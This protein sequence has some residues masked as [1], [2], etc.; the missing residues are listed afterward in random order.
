MGY[1][2]Q[3][4][5]SQVFDSQVFNS[6]V[7]DKYKT[8]EVYHVV[9]P[10]YTGNFMPSKLDL[11]L[12]DVDEYV[13]S[14]TVTRVPAVATNEAKTN[15][16]L[17]EVIVNGDSPPPKRTVDGVKQTYPPTTAEEK[18]ARKN[19]LMARDLETLS[20]DD[21][22]NNLKSMKLKLKGHQSQAKTHKILSDV[23]IYSFFAN[24]S[25][26]PHLDNEDLQ[27]I[28]ADDL[29]EIDIK[30]QM[31]H[32][33]QKIPKEDWKEGW[34]PRENRNREPAKDGPT[35]FA[36][37][38]YTS[39]GSSSSS[40]SDT[41]VNDKNKTG[42]GYHAVPPP[43]T[44]NFMP[45]KP[46]LIFAD[47]DE[48]AISET[49]T[50]VPVVAT[51]EAKT[52]ESKPKSVSKPIIK[53]WV[54]DSEDEN[55]TETKSKQ[56]KPSFA[57]VEFVKPNEK[58]KSPRESV[59]QEEH[60]RQ[61]K[62]LRKNSQSPRVNTVRAKHV[63]TAR[64]KVST[65]RPK[66]VLNAVKG[67][68]LELQEKRVINSGFSRHMTR[69]MS[70]LSE[71][72]EIDG[73][74]VAFGGDPKRAKITGKGKISTD[75]ECVVL[76]PDFK[77][78]D[79]SQV[80][81]RVLRKNN[82]YSVDLKNVAP[83]G[84]LTCLFV[85]ATL[86]ESNLWHRRLGTINFKTINKLVRGNLVRGLPSKKFKHDHTCVACQ[87]GKQQKASCKFDGK[88]NEGFFVG[89]SVNSKAVRVF[90]NRTKIVEETLHITFLENKPNVTGSGLTWLFDIDTLTKSMNYK[91]VVAGNQSNGSAGKARV[92]TVPGKDY[93]LLPLWTQD[94]LLSFSFKDSPGDRFKPSGDE[95]KR[96]LKIWGM[97]L[98]SP[99]ANA[100]G[101]KDNVIDENI[102]Y[103]CADDPNMPSLK[104]IVYSDED[105]GA[106]ANMTNLDTNIPGYTQE[107]GIVYDEVF[108][109]VARIKA[110]RLFLAYALFKEFIVYQM[111]ENSA[112][113]YGKIEEEVYV[114]LP[115]RS[116]DPE[117]PN[118]V[119]KVE[120]ALYGLH[121]APRARKEM[122][123]EFEKMMHKKFQ[124]S[125]MRDLTF[126]LGL[127]VTQKDGGIFISQDKPDIMFVV[128]ACVRF[129]VTPKVLHLH[130]VKRIFIYLKGQPKLG[131]WYPKDSLFTLE[132][133]TD[134]DYA[135]ASLDKI[136]TTGGC[137]F[138]GSRL[139]L[140]QC[141]KQ[142]IAAN[143]TTEAEYVAASNC[144][145]QV[146]T[147]NS[148]VNVVGHYLVLPDETVHEER[149]DRV[150]RAANTTANLDTEQDSGTIN[151][152]QSTVIPNE[153]IPQGTGSGGSL[154]C[155]DTILGTDLLKLGFGNL[156]SKEES[157]EVG[158][159]EKV[160]NSTTQEEDVEIQGRYGHDTK[161]NTAS[162][163]I[164]TASIN[165]TIV[166]LVTTVST[167]ITT[168][169]VFIST[170]EPSTPPPTTTT[171]VIEDEDL[172]IAQTFI[173]MRSEK[174][175]EKAKERAS[176]EKSN[177]GK[178]KRVKPEKPL[179]KKDQI[180]FDKEVTQRLQAQ[181]QAELEK[182]EKMAR[183]KEEDK[184]ESSGK[185]AVSK[186]R[187]RKGLDE[188]SVKRQKLEDDAKKEELRA[189]LE[190]VQHDDSA[191]SIESLATKYP[192]VDWKTHILS[193]DIQDV[194]DLYR[195]VKERFK[196]TSPE[197]YDRLLWGDLM[198]L[199]EPNKEDEIWKNQQDYIMISGR[200]Y[201]S[202]GIHLLLMNTGTHAG[203]KGISSYTRNAFKN[204]KW[205]ARS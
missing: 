20:M 30:W 36:L 189:F 193:E 100:A 105:V 57:R 58:L 174:S 94:P 154:R 169:G 64:P 188:E 200:L 91:P 172:T 148:S 166:E 181:L 123:T 41:E 171:T 13:V 150:E 126:F 201:D 40:N 42:V 140:W 131:L 119:Y 160:K 80:L 156:S 21:L 62:N 109:P 152:T 7:N 69:N 127:Q 182:E 198:T 103:E 139:I 17:W 86:D 165:I 25:N 132:A 149:G 29:K 19:E 107:E 44:G 46:D 122:C 192:I 35:N 32:G 184:A 137:Q 90:N 56:R 45:P 48:Y 158:K 204:V 194:L 177:K 8:G 116:E 52:S 173:K 66:V 157:Q 155:Q 162:T 161:I 144:C 82:M 12:A 70:Y 164:T 186:K 142:T 104:E 113:L 129:Q 92:E 95:E 15:Y 93:I 73:G 163:S 84:G 101:I 81:F 22:Y 75:I 89:Y 151:R 65:V 5:D 24:Q 96:M 38:A 178:G 53:D 60:N 115:L 88:A 176:K 133:Y 168:A 68:Q 112:F 18:L 175:K 14:E 27:Q 26:S 74:Y 63:N 43:Y 72:E 199:F 3:V 10:P 83:L 11:I 78:L 118:R 4:F 125:S 197:G 51:N 50:S 145:R 146:N 6:Q 196:T 99:T 138:L 106:E 2:R 143:F 187:T 147:G 79:E 191:V 114:C 34:A 97:K 167:P 202:C 153:P 55:E 205:E 54:S 23:V 98:M 110:I 183:Q 1:D 77:L 16:A 179:K 121:Q 37:M 117:F 190:I 108:A 134:S 159:E 141:K 85:K 185:E 124:M 120:K 111:D 71:Y 170:V 9:P 28:D 39:L 33:S 49:V 47:V 135:G 128:C 31:N 76:S 61:A 203:R 130:V 180:E 102:V 195:L 67:N 59:K 136:S 87:K